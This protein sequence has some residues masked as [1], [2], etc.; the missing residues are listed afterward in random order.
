MNSCVWNNAS[1]P[2]QSLFGTSGFSGNLFFFPSLASLSTYFLPI[3]IPELLPL[4]VHPIPKC[5]SAL[6]SCHFTARPLSSLRTFVSVPPDSLSSPHSSVILP[7]E[8]QAP[9][10]LPIPVL[11]TP[12]PSP[13]CV[14][15]VPVHQ[16]SPPCVHPSSHLQP[17]FLSFPHSDTWALW[18]SRE[19]TPEIKSLYHISLLRTALMRKVL[20]CI[21][22]FSTL[23]PTIREGR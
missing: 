17:Q 2:S 14:S 3:P 23:M 18:I 12:I 11:Q 9:T 21:R 13:S 5:P 1:L 10:V 19:W 15:L 4:T 16:S 7:Y 6:A 22:N 20:L 8:L